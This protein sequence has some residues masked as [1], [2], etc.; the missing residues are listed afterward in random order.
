MILTLLYY[1]K[2]Y[3][4]LFILLLMLAGIALLYTFSPPTL[5]K[6]REVVVMDNPTLI[7]DAQKLPSEGKI[8]QNNEYFIYLKVSENYIALLYPMLLNSLNSEDKRCL[9]PP[10]SDEGAHISLAAYTKLLPPNKNIY[11]YKVTGLYK[12]T[13]KKHENGQYL[14]ETWYA[15]KVSLSP[16]LAKLIEKMNPS[17]N[18]IQQAHISIA[19]AK[20]S[21]DDNRCM[22]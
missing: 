21:V 11:A 3:L 12:V 13:F 8:M 16:E 2:K 18:N 14:T 10:P 20:E 6:S 4:A 19:V 22:N 15:L 17:R 1:L 7:G 5:S 9:Q